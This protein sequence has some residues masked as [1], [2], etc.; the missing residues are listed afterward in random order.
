M[1]RWNHRANSKN[2]ELPDESLLKLVHTNKLGLHL[3][4]SK[5][6]SM[7]FGTSQWVLPSTKD[8]DNFEIKLCDEVVERVQVFNIN[9]YMDIKGTYSGK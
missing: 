3:N 2:A 6:K 8:P 5:T 9:V 4:V 1:W 7:L